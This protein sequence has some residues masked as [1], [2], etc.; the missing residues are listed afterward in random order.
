MRTIGKQN[1][2]ASNLDGE[3]NEDYEN[4]FPNEKYVCELPTTTNN[5]NGSSSSSP[6]KDKTTCQP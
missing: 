5:G 6:S 3:D 2:D 4:L 1:I